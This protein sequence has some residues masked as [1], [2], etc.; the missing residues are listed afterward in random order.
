MTDAETDSAD[1]AGPAPHARRR[2]LAV[3]SRFKWQHIDYL[4]ALAEHFD[5]HVAWSVEGHHGAVAHAVRHGMRGWELGDIAAIGITQVRSRLHAAISVCQPEI[6]HVM[7]Y[8]HE[9]LAVLAR[10][11]AGDGALIVFECRDPLTTFHHAPR[12]S[13]LW[14][15]EH[16]A[17]GASDAQILVSRAL[18]RYYERTHDLDL[19]PTS[20]IVPHA[21]ARRTAG[22]PQAKLS[23]AD[24]R[25]HVALVGTVSDDPANGRWYGTVIR[26]L[27]GLGLVVHSHFHE[28]A[29]TLAPYRALAAELAD[30]HLHP[31]VSFRDGTAL[32]ALISRY[33]LMGVFHE[34]DTPAGNASATLAVC[35]PT[36]A[37]CGWLHGAIPVACTRHY[38]GLVEWIED[39]GI[40]FVVD[41]VDDLARVAADRPAIA[42]AT[43]RCLTHRDRF[44][45]EYH[46]LRIRDFVETRLA[47]HGHSPNTDATASAAAAG[48]SRPSTKR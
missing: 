35:M 8:H 1:E 42:A 20:L 30:Y 23:A 10:A 38:G 47:A 22:P 17:L 27:V 34:L 7:Y 28:D 18:R 44:S 11:L 46:A 15:R 12:G 3:V 37:V 29:G 40:G 25:V 14:Q 24:G 39:L 36:K 48:S 4:A 21:F 33:D 41:D 31:T 19:A 32:S 6:V 26:R 45:N 16:D 13:A 43:A 5:V 2:L 9:R